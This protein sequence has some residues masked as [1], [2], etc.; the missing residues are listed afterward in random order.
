M[1]SKPTIKE[2]KSPGEGFRKER[3]ALDTAAGRVAQD[4]DSQNA[5]NTVF[6]YATLSILRDVAHPSC[7]AALWGLVCGSE[8]Q[9]LAT[10]SLA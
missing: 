1:G 9:D 4:M 10:R 7:Y 6:A 5:A 8:A 3:A 2:Q